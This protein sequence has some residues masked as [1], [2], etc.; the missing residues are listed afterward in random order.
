MSGTRRSIRI[1]P[2]AYGRSVMPHSE[3]CMHMQ[4]AGKVMRFHFVS[5]RCVQLLKDLDET[6]FSFPILA[7]EAGIFHDDRGFYYYPSNEVV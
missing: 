2:G 4:V 5:E 3:V 6:N 1:E 7:G